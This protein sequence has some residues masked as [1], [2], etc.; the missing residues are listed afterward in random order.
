MYAGLPVPLVRS[1]SGVQ[2]S[3]YNAY[4]R[5]NVGHLESTVETPVMHALLPQQ[6]LVDPRRIIH[7]GGQREPAPTCV[8]TWMDGA[9]MG[10]PFSS[11]PVPE[12][13]KV[14]N[15]SW[16]F[17]FLSSAQVFLGTFFSLAYLPTFT[18]LAYAPWPPPSPTYLPTCPPIHPSIYLFTHLPT[19]P[20]TY[21]PMYLRT[22][23]PPRQWQCRLMKVLQYTK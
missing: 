12:L 2:K 13:T 22:K 11:L 19:F 21:L 17:L 5:R 20:S 3:N 23:S 10:L 4:A 1:T 8:P 7:Y 6:T 9:L 15:S 18:L 16:P 14:V